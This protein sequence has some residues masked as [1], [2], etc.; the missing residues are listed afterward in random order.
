[1]RL[2]LPFVDVEQVVDEIPDVA[3]S[4]QAMHFWAHLLLGVKPQGDDPLPRVRL[5]ESRP[6][7]TS[8]TRSGSLHQLP[9]G[10]GVRTSLVCWAC[11]F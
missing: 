7:L 6:G 5:P 11:T 8:F 1:M 9:C 2:A 10:S 4:S 3:H